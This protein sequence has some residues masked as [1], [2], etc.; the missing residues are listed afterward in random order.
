MP[1]LAPPRFPTE[2]FLTGTRDG[3]FAIEGGSADA[4][5]FPVSADVLV[6]LG[7]DFFEARSDSS[8]FP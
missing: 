2:G 1:R 5:I 8:A 4:P 7:A 6:I 3:S